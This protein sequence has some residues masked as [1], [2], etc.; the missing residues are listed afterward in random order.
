MFAI[1]ER[2]DSQSGLASPER[3]FEDETG[4]AGNQ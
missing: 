1:R 2:I 3:R 4:A